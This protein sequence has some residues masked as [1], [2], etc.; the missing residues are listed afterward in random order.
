MAGYQKLG[1]NSSNRKALFRDLVTDLFLYE[2]I[3][4]T[5]AKA[6]ELRSVAE[7]LITLAKRGDL[8]ARRQ[9]A[10]FVR[11]ESADGEKDAIQKLFT[12]LGPRYAERPG[13]YTRILKLGPRRGDSAPMVYIELVDRA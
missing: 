12:D 10:S 2:R 9:V 4:T 3:Q 7:K 1:R 5:E 6:K 8:H 11:R 13:G